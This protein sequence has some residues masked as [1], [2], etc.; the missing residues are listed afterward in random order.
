MTQAKEPAAGRWGNLL[1][2]EERILSDVSRRLASDGS[3]DEVMAAL[4]G[5]VRE[6]LQADGATLALR[7][8]D[9]CY[10]AEGDAIS[11]LWKRRRV[12]MNA[13][14]SGWCMSRRQPIAVADI[15]QDPRIPADAFRPNFVRGLAMAPVGRSEPVAALGA[16]WQEPHLV[17][18]GDLH[19]L[20]A[21][22]DATSAAQSLGDQPERARTP[23]GAAR[24]SCRARTASCWTPSWWISP[25]AR[26]PRAR[27]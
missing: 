9:L 1:P 22:A 27:A 25:S 26:S 16:Y 6:L 10:D 13:C 19:R 12:P 3:L 5:G 14:V 15:Q 2:Q 24:S 23:A 20:Q 8:G 7:E 17:E 18:P 4:S 11:P 21:L